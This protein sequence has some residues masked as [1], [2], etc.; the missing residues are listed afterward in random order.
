MAKVII[1]IVLL[2]LIT[3]TP[4][5]FPIAAYHATKNPINSLS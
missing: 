1:I 3:Y 2:L 5:V 4:I